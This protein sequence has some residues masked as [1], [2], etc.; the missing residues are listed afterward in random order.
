MRTDR[1]PTSPWLPDYAPPRCQAAAVGEQAI[2]TIA[3]PVG[4][5]VAHGSRAT[6]GPIILSIQS[7]RRITMLSFVMNGFY[8]S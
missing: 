8:D 1:Q 4:L 3:Q 7:G 2:A 5:R 6:R